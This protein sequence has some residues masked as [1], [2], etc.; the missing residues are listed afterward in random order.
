MK[1]TKP[2]N[3]LLGGYFKLTKNDFSEDKNEKMKK[4]LYASVVGS[5]LYG[6]VCTI[7]DIVYTLDA[8][9]R[10]LTRLGREHW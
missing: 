6:M 10:H 4:V 3:V 5:M 8:V 2:I 7:P 9:S 1:N